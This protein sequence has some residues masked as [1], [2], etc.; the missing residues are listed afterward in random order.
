MDKL[1]FKIATQMYGYNAE[2]VEILNKLTFIEEFK[3]LL[4]KHHHST[5]SD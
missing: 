2:H 5:L 4:E 1:L 3:K